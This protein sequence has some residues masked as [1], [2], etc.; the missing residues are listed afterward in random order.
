MVIFS[1][2]R[3]DNVISLYLCVPQSVNLASVLVEDSVSLTVRGGLSVSAPV[4]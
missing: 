1:F 4:V 3:V 2:Y